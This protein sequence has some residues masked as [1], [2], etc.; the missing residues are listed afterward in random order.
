MCL[1][2]FAFSPGAN[3]DVRYPSLLESSDVDGGSA[4][5]VLTYLRHIIDSIEHPDLVRL[6]LRYLFALHEPYTKI[7]P[8][9]R[10][11]TLAQRRKSQDLITHLARTGDKISPELFNLVDLI[12]ASLGSSSQQTISATLQL[13]S[14]M[15]HRQRHQSL[16]TLLKTRVAK[17]TDAQR[18]FGGQLTETDL[19]LSMAENLADFDG[20]EQSYERYLYDSRNILEY[21]P[22][23][24]QLLANHAQLRDRISY[25][26]K[27]AE[28]ITDS[29][30]LMHD[31]QIYKGIVALLHQYFSNDI[32]T[33]LSLTG[34]LISLASCGHLRLEGWLLV[35]PKN[36]RYHEEPVGTEID[37]AAMVTT[38]GAYG[39]TITEDQRIHKLK[40]ARRTPSWDA[41]DRSPIVKALDTLARQVAHFRQEVQDF[42]VFLLKCRTIVGVDNHVEDVSATPQDHI[43]RTQE[44][45]PSPSPAKPVPPIG[46]ISSHFRARELIPGNNESRGSSPRGRQPT[47][48]TATL[49]GRFSQLYMSPSRSSSQIT[50][51]AYSPSPLRKD[52]IAIT[53][54]RPER[55]VRPVVEEAFYRRVKVSNELGHDRENTNNLSNS[56]TSSV[57]SQSSGSSD[58]KPQEQND[59]SLGHLLTNV[60][61]LQELLLELAAIVDVRGTLF[62]EV[63]FQG[64]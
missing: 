36:Y 6:S 14:I 9:A 13:L 32:E 33:N 26:S 54:P 45:S 43:R 56:E 11:T 37:D 42:D 12:N 5:A 62:D 39:A 60:V 35:N 41:K 28:K 49:A 23:S 46:S 34:V 59:V 19:L 18:T 4:V 31:D 20:L 17:S 16:S 10:P 1:K 63:E 50:S 27:S 8:S 44:S 64:G 38:Q 7:E 30:I 61:I 57:R 51:R 47:P 48:S 40:L 58:T 25:P 15:L 53:P 55:S 24:I 29:Y 52:L 22:C 2:P 21:H 3:W